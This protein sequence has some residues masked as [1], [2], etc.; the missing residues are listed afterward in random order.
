MSS[1]LRFTLFFIV[2]YIEFYFGHDINTIKIANLI[3]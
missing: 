3:F 2:V 1:A